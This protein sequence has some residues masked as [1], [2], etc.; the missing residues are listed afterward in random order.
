[1]GMIPADKVAR[2]QI[3][4]SSRSRRFMNEGELEAL[5]TLVDSVNPKGVL[6]FGINTGRTAQAI[7]EYVPGIEQYIGIDVPM[8]YVTNAQVQRGEVP[9]VAGELV[10]HDERVQLIVREGGSHAVFPTDLPYVDAVFIDGDHSRSGVE[11]DTMLA[12]QRARPGGIIVWHD[13]H[14]LGTVD[15]REVL[16]EKFKRG[17]DLRHV[18]GTWLVYGR[19]CALHELAY[20]V[21]PLARARGVVRH[22]GDHVASAPVVDVLLDEQRPP[23]GMLDGVGSQREHQR[24]VYLVV[25]PAPVG[26]TVQRLG[27]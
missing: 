13:Y 4:W 7:L 23:G 15:V 12:L 27:A 6:E 18:E 17:W 16:N 5:V 25:S 8:G 3:N 11:H 20:H 21:G 22:G 14:D 10:L 19:R 24:L 2:A 26:R 1:M 9:K